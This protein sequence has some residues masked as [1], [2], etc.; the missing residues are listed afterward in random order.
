MIIERRV[1]QAIPRDGATI[2]TLHRLT[3]LGAVDLVN[4]LRGLIERGYAERVDTKF[5]VISPDT[6]APRVITKHL[7]QTRE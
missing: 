5:Y 6:A 4:A 2:E 3:G 1:Y 7:G